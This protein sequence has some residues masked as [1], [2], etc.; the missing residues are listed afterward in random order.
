MRVDRS[1]CSNQ[2]TWSENHPQCIVVH[3]TDNFAAGADARAHARAQYQGNFQIMSAHYYVDDGEIAYQAAPH[4]RGCWHVG[5]NYGS[6]NLFGRYGNR[7]SIAVEMCVQKGYDYETAFLHTVELVKNLMNETGIPSDAV[8]RHY[9]ICS[10]NCPSQIQKRGDWERFQ[11]LIRETEDGSEKSE[12]NPGI[13]RVTDPAL[14]IRTGPGVE[15]PVVGVIKDREAIRSQK[16]E[17]KAG[18][19][20]CRERDGSTAIKHIVFTGEEYK[21]PSLQN[22]VIGR[23]DSD[24]KQGVNYSYDAGGEL[25]NTMDTS[26]A[27]IAQSKEITRR[28]LYESNMGKIWYRCRFDSVCYY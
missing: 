7:N 28:K 27:N 21:I 1:Y 10:K 4:S 3:N 6:K 14:N 9:D 5:R 15:Y 23:I 26:G 11:R 13:Y 22:D 17:T 12:Y 18:A 24:G 25:V 16:S 8:Y 20:C 2:N 19:D